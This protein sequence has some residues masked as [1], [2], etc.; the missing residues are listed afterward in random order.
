[1]KTNE[2]SFYKTNE[3]S[4]A[5]T[6]TGIYS[7]KH[8]LLREGGT[9]GFGHPAAASFRGLPYLVLFLFEKFQINRLDPARPPASRPRLTRDECLC[10]LPYYAE[11]FGIKPRPEPSGSRIAP[12]YT[13]LFKD[14]NHENE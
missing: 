7:K 8:I 13:L 9:E 4:F 14:L 2:V 3:V 11:S 12:A 1:M 10:F 5:K 6:L